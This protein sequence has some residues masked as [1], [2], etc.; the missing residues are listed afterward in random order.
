MSVGDGM[1]R[2]LPRGRCHSGIPAA[3]LPGINRQ[4]AIEFVSAVCLAYDGAL[5]SFCGDNQG[6]KVLFV[7]ES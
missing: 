2:L 4:I 3:T 1:L 7:E 6:A 5:S